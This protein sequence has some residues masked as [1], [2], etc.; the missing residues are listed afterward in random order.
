MAE[1]DISV[2]V[3]FLEETTEE[4][5]NQWGGGRWY[6]YP[7]TVEQILEQFNTRKD[8]TLYFVIR[9]NNEIIGSFE[10]DFINWEE[11]TCGVCRYLIKKEYR[12]QGLGTEALKVA[13]KYAFSELKM[14]KITLSVFDFNIGAYKCYKKAGFTEYERQTRDNGW[15]AVKME[16]HN[17]TE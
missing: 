7:V 2:V 4:F 9:N 15:I 8:N 6:K 1:E 13:I 11:K 17:P 12:S 5:M 14:K 16:I 10:F 3:S